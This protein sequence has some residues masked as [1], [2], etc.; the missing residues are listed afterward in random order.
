MVLE[1]KLKRQNLEPTGENLGKV[2]VEL[3]EKNGPGA[4][5]ELLKESIPRIYS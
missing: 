1:Q 2:D 5:A 4:V 3:R